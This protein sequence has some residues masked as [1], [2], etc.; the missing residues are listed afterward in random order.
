MYISRS[1]YSSVALEL[2][3]RKSNIQILQKEALKS[4]QIEIGGQ[5]RRQGPQ[6]M[7]SGV[8]D[9]LQCS[10]KHPAIFAEEI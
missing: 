7:L 8:V 9:E 5:I 10:I 1:N 6:H 2:N 4:K 3:H